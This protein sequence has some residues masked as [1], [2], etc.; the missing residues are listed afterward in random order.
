MTPL[1]AWENL[2][3]VERESQ[4]LPESI[5]TP[6]I[7]GFT[8]HMNL[9]MG[10]VKATECW[11][12][13]YRPPTAGDLGSNFLYRKSEYLT[14]ARLLLSQGRVAEARSLLEALKPVAERSGY[15]GS[16]I[17]ILS[18]KAVALHRLGERSGAMVLLT[19]ALHLAQP[20]GYVATFVEQGT[21]MAEMLKQ[22]TAQQCMP[23]YVDRLLAVM[24]QPGAS[25]SRAADLVEPLSAREME[26]MQ[27]VA[28]GRSN[29][30]IAAD[31][32]IATGTVKKHQRNIFGKL[33]VKSR[34]QCAAKARELNLL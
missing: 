32:V 19:Q 29:H 24:P 16:V 33:G 15:T 7:A 4:A 13:A 18:L 10:D 2:Y 23:G 31:L 6:Y 3:K 25:Q 34:T 28:A 8:A 26:V 17:E 30:E 27:L 5:L 9:S 1:R 21:P 12:A 22:A 14:D 20:E 11:A